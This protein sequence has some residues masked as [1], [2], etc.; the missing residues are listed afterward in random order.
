MYALYCRIYQAIL[1]A[2]SYV[3]PWRQPELIDGENS[4]DRLPK[5][6]Q[7][8]GI[9]S[10]LIV[11]DKGILSVGLI[12]SL[13]QGLKEAGIRYAVYDKTVP[14]PTVDNIMEATGVYRQN[15]CEAIIA[16]G[17]GSPMDCGKGVGAQIARP[18]KTISQMRGL[19]KVRK[20]IPPFF[21]VPTTAGTGSEATL[22][23]VIT[24]SKT[25][26]KYAINDVSLIPYF[27]VL[28]P[29]LTRKLPPHLTATTGM[30]ALTHAVEAYIGKSNTNKT[31]S[32]SEKA[33]KLIFDN[34]YTAYSDGDNLQA[35]D[36]MQKASYYAGVAFT[37]A[38]VGYV[39]AIAH[40]LGGLYGVPHG[41]ANAVILPYMLTYY[42]KSVYTPLARLAE[43]TGIAAAGDTAEQKARAFIQAIEDLNRNMD[44]PAAID[45]I[46]ESDIPIMTQRACRE[47]NPLYPVPRILSERDIHAVIDMIKA[48]P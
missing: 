16:F 30:D 7:E 25:H 15:K 6:I 5:R 39:H 47:A 20:R 24:D 22:A 14:N 34:I 46:R 18:N 37:R 2:V 26:E 35:R 45:G 1:R 28:D 27:A 4:L 13:L 3:L 44:I 8:Q 43:R 31:K 41:L 32:L 29:T 38:Y 9:S 48:R 33:V 21:A 11:T 12:D 17:G 10:V 23:A 36:N 40:T 19:L 42:G